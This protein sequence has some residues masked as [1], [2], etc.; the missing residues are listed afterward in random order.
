LLHYVPFHAL[1][2]GNRYLIDSFTVS[3]APSASIFA[4]CRRKHANKTGPCLLMGIPD[5]QTPCIHEEVQSVARMVPQ[6]EVFLGRNACERVLRERGP[7]SRLIH[8]ATHGFFR[9]DSPMLS[10]I[11]L[12][13]TFLTLTDLYQLRLQ[14]NQVTLSG[15]STGL[16]V[17]AP[18]DELIGLVRGLLFAGARSLLLTLWDVND[19]STAEFMKAFYGRCFNHMD[20]AAALQGAMQELREHYPHPYYW[21][22]FVLVGNVSHLPEPGIQVAHDSK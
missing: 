16:N 13:D 10:G 11:R 3:Y 20:T 8:I 17:I 7:D 18:G 1:F 2:D 9:R 5:A 15:C 4:Q 19:G 6:P 12:G 14:A 22:P 21:A